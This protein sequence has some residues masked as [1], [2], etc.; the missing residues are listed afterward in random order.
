MKFTRT[1]AALFSLLPALIFYPNPS[2]ADQDA[3]S[4]ARQGV[5]QVLNLEMDNARK[6]F[7]ELEK[8]YPGF[9]LTQFLKAS[10]DWAEAEVSSGDKRNSMRDRA[11][12]S[13]LKAA[14]TAEA[15]IEKLGDSSAAEQW[16][17]T[18][19]MSNFFAARMYADSGHTLRAYHL[20]RSGRDELRELIEKHPDDNDAYLVLGMYE[21]IAGSI[22]RSLRWLAALLDLSGD[23]AL[24]VKYLERASAKAPVM[25]PEAARMLLVAAGIFP[26]TTRSCAY[27]PM[28]KYVRQ[29]Y[30][31]NPH[32]SMALQLLYVNCGYPR[33]A[34]DE[35]AVAEKQFQKDFPNLKDE[36]K[37]IR[38]YAYRELG[39]IDKVMAMKK[40][41]PRDQDYWNLILAE[42]YDVVGEHKKAKN[43]YDDFFW[44]DVNGREIKTDS[45]PPSDWI[46]DRATRYRKHPY[47]PA[48]PNAR[49]VGD[50]LY[51]AG[52]KHS[53]EPV[54]D[55]GK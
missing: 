34:L 7:G 5:D 52:Q 2:F 11:I 4:L 30:P 15:Q 1:L 17:L 35:M 40:D 24:G 3:N 49:I 41:F 37:V 16:H 38:V 23:R 36:F 26:E 25:A 44:S 39:Q 43:I 45:G 47:Q 10:V 19:G 31:A 46:I 13:M 33:K 21:Y 6:T 55:S 48:D 27:L 28:A 20:G 32:Y 9:A 51:L 53:S 29:K 22:P 42:T 54:A 18:R 12:E 8:K 14:N 50:Y